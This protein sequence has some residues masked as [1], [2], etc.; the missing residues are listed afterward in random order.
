MTK[1]IDH[2]GIFGYG[3][4]VNRHAR[5]PNA[6]AAPAEIL[7]WQRWWK[8]CVTTEAGNVC[9]LTILATPNAR[10][11]GVLIR[12]RRDALPMLDSREQGYK[13]VQLALKQ[14]VLVC[15][16]DAHLEAFTYTS[17]SSA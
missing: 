9:A 12:E 4:L 1:V 11:A 15:A 13:R 10:V 6:S 3:S 17:N 7:G 16:G 5:R 2:V 8:H 14:E